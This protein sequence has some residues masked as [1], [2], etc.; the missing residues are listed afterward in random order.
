MD[1]YSK[2]CLKL[3]N[4]SFS[5]PWPKT[6]PELLNFAH[7]EISEFLPYVAAFNN[8]YGLRSDLKDSRFVYRNDLNFDWLCGHQSNLIKRV[9]DWLYKMPKLVAFY[10]LYSLESNRLSNIIE[11]NSVSLIAKFSMDSKTNE[12]NYINILRFF[13][14]WLGNPFATVQK[15]ELQGNQVDVL[16]VPKEVISYG[17]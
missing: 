11:F 6:P 4:W 5:E 7:Q 14:Y 3:R 12:E 1:L 8:L 9:R 10:G 15:R 16:C 2:V 13:A 17:V